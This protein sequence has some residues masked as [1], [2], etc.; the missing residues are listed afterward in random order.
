[1]SENKNAIIDNS[2]VGKRSIQNLSCNWTGTADFGRLVPF[3]WT[4]LL[5][6]D[7]VETC[8]PKIELS[9]LP[10]A[11]PTFGKMDLYVHYFFVPTRLLFDAKAH[12]DFLV[13][14]G[15]YKSV[16]A[17]YFTK[18]DLYNA[19]QPVTDGIKRSYFK[20]WTSMGLPPFFTNS[21]YSDDETDALTALPF[22]A[23][24]QIW[25]DYYRDPE[26]LRDDNY[27][28]VLQTSYGRLSVVDIR[29][30]FIPRYRNIK[31]CWI[32]NLF[33]SNGSQP[34]NPQLYVGLHKGSSSDAVYTSS[35]QS[36]SPMLRKVEALTRLAERM[37]LSGKREIDLLFTRYGIKPEWDKLQMCQY[38][39]GGK[40]TVMVQDITATADTTQV[41]DSQNGTPL[42]AQA[43]RGYSALGSVNINFT[44]T[45]PGILLGLFSV[46]PHVHFVQGIGKE[47][48]RRYRDDFFQNHLQHVGQ[49]AVSKQEVGHAYEANGSQMP[50]PVSENKQTFA[51]TEPY[52]EY[53]RGVDILAG[54]FMYYHNKANDSDL[55]EARDIQYMQ[56]M[57]MYIDYPLNRLYDPENLQIRPLEF[58]KIFFYLGGNNWENVDDHFHLCI[59]K[60]IR[61]NRPMD[62]FAVPTVET[63]EDPHATKTAVK[64]SVEL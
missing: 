15:V 11:S 49:V 29:N 39:G 33:A 41:G 24:N 6:T 21:A 34:L 50:Y 56:S 52:Y 59:D 57:E 54:D 63:T 60:D 36:T 30:Y 23:Y 28:Q 42:G 7:K 16:S 47:W 26:V 58:N 18:K 27:E 9:M 44:A 40:S 43:G 10:L 22:R 20:H 46:M 19:Y 17:P 1:M 12:R 8:H 61:V 35:D 55:A 45:E 13:D 31:D 25:W 64:Q 53:K 48:I 37:S 14:S 2:V 62:G 38:V 32:A 3:Q 51:F 5:G 4:E